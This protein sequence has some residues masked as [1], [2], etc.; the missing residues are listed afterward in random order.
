MQVRCFVSLCFLANALPLSWDV[1][2][3]VMDCAWLDMFDSNTSMWWENMGWCFHVFSTYATLYTSYISLMYSNVI[4]IIHALLNSY[5]ITLCHCWLLQCFRPGLLSELQKFPAPSMPQ[6]RHSWNDG[7]NCSILLFVGGGK[8]DTGR[9]CKNSTLSQIPTTCSILHHTSSIFILCAKIVATDEST[10]HLHTPGAHPECL[11]ATPVRQRVLLSGELSWFSVSTSPR[12]GMD[13]NVIFVVKDQL[14]W[15]SPTLFSMSI[16]FPW[17]WTFVDDLIHII[18]LTW[19]CFLMLL[20]VC[21]CLKIAVQSHSTSTPSYPTT[22]SW[23]AAWPNLKLSSSAAQNGLQRHEGT[24]SGKC[25]WESHRLGKLFSAF[26]EPTCWKQGGCKTSQKRRL[27][28]AYNR[29]LVGMKTSLE[30][31]ES[32]ADVLF[33]LEN[34]EQ[35]WRR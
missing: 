32:S 34:T 3:A 27:Q 20:S 16:K 19:L 2:N 4:I 31:E 22:A 5:F 11:L 35:V 28:A 26:C 30:L 25:N 29:P 12:L 6:K 8:Q 21:S 33:L 17:E 1:S 24:C 14:V 15:L 13:A 10:S 9:R 7:L 23:R 18:Y